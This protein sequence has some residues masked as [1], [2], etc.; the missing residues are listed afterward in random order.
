MSTRYIWLAGVLL[1]GPASAAGSGMAAGLEECTALADDGS[2]LACYDRL[3]G[4]TAMPGPAAAAADMPR[5]GSG[6]VTAPVAPA[7]TLAAGPAA[8]DAAPV[9]VAETV[10]SPR[11]SVSMAERWELEPQYQDGTFK[12]KPYAPVYLMPLNFRQ[13]INNDP[14]SSNPVNCSHR[15]DQQ[16]DKVGV[17]FQLSFKTKL[18][19]DM[20]GSD[21]DLWAAY[22]QTSYWQAYDSAN[23]SPFRETDYQPELWATLPVSW[24]PEAFRLRMVN[25]GLMHQSNGQTNPLSRSW[26]RVFASFGFTSGDL[27]VIV[28]PWWRIPEPFPTDNNPD[29]SDYMG[30]VEVLASYP[31]RGQN[32]SLL[33]RNNLRFGSSVPN[34]TFTQLE[35]AFPIS[36]NLHGFVQAFNGWGESM[37]NYNFHNRGIGVGISMTEWR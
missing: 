25:L 20:L 12:F 8:A 28:K 27:S 11:R 36:G 34:R 21:A 22:T 15:G 30:R 17:K 14:C 33:L 19:Q 31:W 16:Y 7:A 5:A 6:S 35:W 13:R 9:R 37:Q 24:G 4:R 3:A 2:R 18:W 1:A 26:N 32:F 10:F 23:S 29:I